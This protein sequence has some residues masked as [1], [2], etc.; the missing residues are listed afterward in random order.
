MAAEIDDL[1]AYLQDYRRQRE[2]DQLRI[3]TLAQQL[4]QKERLY[5]SIKE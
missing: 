5:L 3:A 4:E 1:N 2:D